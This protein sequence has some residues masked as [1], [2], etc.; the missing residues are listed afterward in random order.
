VLVIDSDIARECIL[1]A[2]AEHGQLSLSTLLEVECKGIDR[3]VT[4]RTLHKLQSLGKVR[5]DPWCKWELVPG[6]RQTS[7]KHVEPSGIA[8][9]TGDLHGD[10][11]T[12]QI[13]S[14][15]SV[16]TEETG[17]RQPE[18]ASAELPDVPSETP[19]E[20]PNPFEDDTY[21]DVVSEL[22]AASERL[23]EAGFSVR[24]S[25]WLRDIDDAEP[26]TIEYATHASASQLRLRDIDDVARRVAEKPPR[27]VL[28]DA[29][30]LGLRVSFEL[31]QTRAQREEACAEVGRLKAELV[32][33]QAA[34]EEARMHLDSLLQRETKLERLAE[35]L[36]MAT[37]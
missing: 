16:I 31:E 25:D 13:Q 20:A 15:V 32:M 10:R 6:D 2:L 37:K 9:E 17:D 8:Y 29:A 33:A 22:D 5:R 27:D 30:D 1:D 4:E 21:A 35:A 14:E 36:A 3:N 12:A 26:R 23:S 24:A 11:Q 34:E 28:E 7:T 19:S 18:P